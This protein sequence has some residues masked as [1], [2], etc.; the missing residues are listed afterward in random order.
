MGRTIGPMHHFRTYLSV[1]RSHYIIP[2]FHP[3]QN[4]SDREVTISSHSQRHTK[5]AQRFQMRQV[6]GYFISYSDTRAIMDNLQI[7]D[8]GVEDLMLKFPINDWLAKTKRFNIVCTTVGHVYSGYKDAEGVFLITHIKTIR[9][10]RSQNTETLV[11]R[12]KDKY[13]K[14]WLV[15]EGEAK[16]DS[17]Q[18]MSFPDGDKLFLLSDGTRP[19]RNNFKGPWFHYQ[20][21]NDQGMR[22]M[23]SGKKASEWAAEAIANGEAV[24]RIWPP[25]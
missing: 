23:Q 2:T 16:E 20:L 13:V 25:Q 3:A 19:E 9:R 22:M 6:A 21:T 1:T 11:E 17:L 10:G 14:K 7:P 5:K 8:K 18:W 15:E 24:E 4:S 12:D